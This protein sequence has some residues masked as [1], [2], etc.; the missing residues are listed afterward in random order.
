MNVSSSATP[1]FDVKESPRNGDDLARGS[2]FGMV[3]VTK[4]LGI[5]GDR[6]SIVLGDHETCLSWNPTPAEAGIEL[7]EVVVLASPVDR[8]TQ[9]QVRHY[10]AEHGREDEHAELHELTLGPDDDDRPCACEG[11]DPKKPE[12]PARGYEACGQ[13]QASEPGERRAGVE[14]ASA[15]SPMQLVF[16]PHVTHF[17]GS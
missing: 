2:A 13:K 6:V 17:T 11:P 15:P 8:A 4:A 7:K 12:S 9:G 10:N 3:E 14:G 1:T 5:H 16:V